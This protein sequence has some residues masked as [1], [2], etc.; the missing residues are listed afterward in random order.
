M[1]SILSATVVALAL[2]PCVRA[3][4][5][6][7]ED[8]FALLIGK[9]LTGWKTEKGDSLDGKSEAFSSRFTVKDGELH[10][11]PK[12]KGDVKIFT[13]REFDKD[14]TIKFDFLPDAKCNNDLF[15]RGIK[16]D[17]SAA[18]VKDW[19]V[20]EWNSLEIILKGDKAEFKLNDK[21]LKTLPA[22]AKASTFGIRAEFGE[23]KVRQLRV[24]EG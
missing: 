14:V 10:I 17:L 2:A 11:D 13:T 8:G 24:K 6:K 15:L 12:V 9:D 23:M 7:L 20:G 19:K 4:D 22:K 18:N 16:F 21:S 1:R 5:F 3:D